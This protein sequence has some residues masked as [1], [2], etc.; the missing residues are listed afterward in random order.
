MTAFKHG[1]NAEALLGG[2]DISGYLNSADTNIDVDT[3]ETTTFKKDWKTHIVGDSAGTIEMGGLYDPAL[4]DITDNLGSDPGAVLT[5]A[6]SGY[7][8]GDLARLV[9]VLSTKMSESSPV[10][11][12]VMFKWSVKA[13]GPIGFGHILHALAEET[14]DGSSTYFDGGASSANGAI[15]HLHVTSTDD[16]LDVIVEDSADHSSWSTIGTFTTKSAAGAERLV[17]TGTVQRY[18]RVSFTL[19]GVSSTFSVSLART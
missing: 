19:A 11:G 8:R 3:A 6:P 7:T 15:A 9:S 12:V 1:R 18:L 17:I 13:D 2:K 16:D 4:T 14:S 10:G 5:V